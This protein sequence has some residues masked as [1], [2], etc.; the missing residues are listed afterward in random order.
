MVKK[1]LPFLCSLAPL[2]AFGADSIVLTDGMYSEISTGSGVTVDVF[3]ITGDINV[4]NAATLTPPAVSHG[5]L[6]ILNGTDVPFGISSN[7]GIDVGGVVNIAATRGL[8][9]GGVNTVNINGAVT[10]NGSFAV[11]NAS[12]L[13]IG[14][15]VVAADDL[16]LSANAMTVHDVSVSGDLTLTTTSGG[17]ALNVG[18][19]AASGANSD[20]TSAGAIVS[21]GTIQNSA[22]GTM[23][24]TSAGAISTTGNLENSGGT[25]TTPTM[26][27]NAG[28]VGNRQNVTIGG[29]VKNDN[30]AG[31]LNIYANNLYV[32]GGGAANPSFVNAGL[33]TFNIDGLTSFANGLDLS[34]MGADSKFVLNTGTL[35]FGATNNDVANDKSIVNIAVNAGP[36]NAGAISNGTLNGGTANANANMKLSGVGGVNV[37]SVYNYGTKIINDGTDNYS[38]KIVST[39]LGGSDPA[40]GN[41]TVSGAVFGAAGTQTVINASDTLSIGSGIADSVSNY[42]NMNLTGNIV[43]LYGVS[44]NGTV[45]IYGATTTGG[46]VNVDGSV[47]NAGNGTMTISATN[48][49]INDAVTNSNGTLNVS[50]GSS[51][52]ALAMGSIGVSGGA[53]NLDSWNGGVAVTG[54]TDVS[55]GVLNLGAGVHEFVSGGAISVNR[56]VYLADVETNGNGDIYLDGTG[57]VSF[58]STSTLTIGG[59]V[60]AT[61]NATRVATFDG[62][63]ISVN[64]ATGIN[65]QNAG[66]VIFGTGTIHTTLH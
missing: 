8:M 11:S 54:T 1:I 10:A 22:G 32:N 26:T 50:G 58:K 37:S 60:I 13:L 30:V 35:S 57:G 2:Y 6:Y 65:A 36:L 34:G 53:V 12:S 49:T 25:A 21:N 5:D 56:N 3:S 47:V 18:T 29:T 62:T 46:A 64:G 33:A 39:A 45:N 7:D 48:V 43:S 66:H 17:A 41:I 23:T 20:I 55:G 44:N 24:I 61:D 16:S 28:S 14:G 38:L 19:I 31:K 15:S 27:V 9:L 4:V 59:N 51:T 42:G 52:G 63:V 40:P